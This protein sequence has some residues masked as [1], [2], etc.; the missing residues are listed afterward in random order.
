MGHTGA[1]PSSLGS[2]ARLLLTV[3]LL[4]TAVAP[5]PATSA[6]AP[7]PQQ[8]ASTLEER[9]ERIGI[10]DAVTEVPR[11]APG[12]ARFFRIWF[13]LP[14]DHD[15][16]DG[17]RF[18]LRATLVHRGADRPTVLATS[19]YHLNTWRFPYDSEVTR[20]V[21]G[22]QVTVEHR[23]FTPS[24]PRRP[25]WATQL[26]IRQSAA[27][28]HR[29]VGALK[30]IYERRWL[31]TGISKGGMT[32]T[33]HRRFY[34]DDV[35]ATIAYVA[36]NDAVD[37]ADVYDDFQADVGGAAYA[38]CRAD[39][40]AVQR[41][42][43]D[44]R[45]WFRDRLA[46]RAEERGLRF[47]L[48]GSLD[49][50]LEVAVIE[51]YFAFWQYQHAADACP[52]VPGPGATRTD[53]WRWVDTVAGWDWLSNERIRPYVPYYFQAA[54]ELGSPAPYEEPIADLLR[55]PGHDVPAS[56]VPDALEPLDVDPAAMAGVDAWVRSSAS[57]MLFVYGELDP[58]S[59]E[60]FACGPDGKERQCLVRWVPEGNH[61][62]NIGLLPG[63]ARRAA[64]ARI[65]RWA[66]VSTGEAAVAAA[67][68]RAL[69][70]EPE[71]ERR[72]AVPAG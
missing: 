61:G 51:L 23:F 65:R 64:V 43:L 63:D 44:N 54:T 25:D 37:T 46:E 32:M 21:G 10:V 36:P 48:I 29:I 53:V 67:E 71:R 72:T 66:G 28:Q 52:R 3:V 31:S 19:G 50:A 41:R 40:V 2:R 16:P 56:F 7:V 68:R 11:L 4:L 18:R 34:P 60:P 13:R 6:A 9:L 49:H 33:Y 39:L 35:A 58:W 5:V 15:R 12:G 26:T 70:V 57:R 20:I 17:R 59:A 45:R 30:R 14:V 62:A 47:G 1:V 69:W 38:D 24:R 27:D 42:V 8:R 22:N 55:H